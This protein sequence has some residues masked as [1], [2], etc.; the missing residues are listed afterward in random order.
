MVIH[1][2][3]VR[4]FIPAIIA[5]SG[6]TA[7]TRTLN[8]EEYLRCLEDKLQEETKEYL[9][10]PCMEEI[11]DILEVI[12]AICAARNYDMPQLLS[13][14]SKKRSERGGFA[15]RIYLESVD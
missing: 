15:D 4:D 10:A 3:L 11:A 9:S 2:K 5:R 14:K 6:R 12:E 7:R 8:E 1:N 13:I